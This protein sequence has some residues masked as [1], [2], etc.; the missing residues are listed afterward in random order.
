ME[1]IKMTVAYLIFEKQSHRMLPDLS[2]MVH[3]RRS[4]PP[5]YLYRSNRSPAPEA[6]VRVA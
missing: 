2:L 1:V 6:G 3:Y 5:P 4:S